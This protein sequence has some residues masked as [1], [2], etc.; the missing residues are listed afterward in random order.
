MLPQR[1]IRSPRL[2]RFKAAEQRFSCALCIPQHAPYRMQRHGRS[3]APHGGV[4]RK[5]VVGHVDAGRDLMHRRRALHEAAAVQQRVAARPQVRGA[6][7][8]ADL[9]RY[10]SWVLRW[11][12]TEQV[13]G[14][15]AS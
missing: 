1:T 6:A 9:L 4:G 11:D 14:F 7:A 10:G 15:I 12:A 2:Y 13:N 5:R 3:P 8:V